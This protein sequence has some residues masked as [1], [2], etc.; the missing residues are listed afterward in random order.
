MADYGRRLFRPG[1]RKVTLNFALAQGFPL[2]ADKL[3]A[4]FDPDLFLIKI[5]PVNP[6]VSALENDL[7]PVFDMYRR[8]E[9]I[10]GKLR[11]A[12]YEVL[13]SLGE[14]EENAI[15]SNCGQ[16]IR[17]FLASKKNSFQKESYS[18][19]LKNLTAND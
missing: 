2:E 7:R 10:V 13:I 3:L 4:Y 6:T 12:G 16:F 11:R 15:G 17:S 8:D 1:D 18:Y 14:S 9:D 19:E 5:T